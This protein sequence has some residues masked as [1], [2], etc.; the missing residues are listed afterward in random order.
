MKRRRFVIGTG[1]FAA[2]TSIV[3]GS[4]AFT[5]TTADRSVSISVAD[6]DPNAF[7]AITAESEIA[8]VGEDGTIEITIDEQ[9]GTNDGKGVG[10]DSSYTFWNVFSVQNY[11]TNPVNVYGEPGHLEDHEGGA[12]TPEI[13]EP[14]DNEITVTLLDGNGNELDIQELQPGDPKETVSVKIDTT[15][16]EPGAEPHQAEYVLVAEAVE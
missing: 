6:E 15:D 3:L 5:T 11:G 8:E 7:L 14:T 12:G 9:L 10:V 16:V 2:S 13:V 4:G 1:V